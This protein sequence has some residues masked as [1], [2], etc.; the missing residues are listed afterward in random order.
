MITTSQTIVVPFPCTSTKLQC[1]GNVFIF[2]FL[3]IENNSKYEYMIKIVDFSFVMSGNEIE[4]NENDM[5]LPLAYQLR[6]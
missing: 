1:R 6:G 4:D 2:F 5:W 3:N